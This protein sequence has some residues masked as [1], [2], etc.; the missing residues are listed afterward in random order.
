VDHVGYAHKASVVIEALLG[1]L[2]VGSYLW[3]VD[4]VF[5]VPPFV[6]L[7]GTL[8]IVLVI[9]AIVEGAPAE[10]FVVAAIPVGIAVAAV[11]LWGDLDSM[12]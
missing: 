3:A 6:A 12:D 4:R 1:A 8:G 7:W 5:G 9:A 10:I 2:F 11:L